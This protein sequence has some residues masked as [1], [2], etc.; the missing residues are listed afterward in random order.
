MVMEAVAEAATAGWAV[1]VV[2]KG[3]SVGAGAWVSHLAK[4]FLVINKCPGQV[5]R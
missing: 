5:V 4:L 3:G 2:E 1:T